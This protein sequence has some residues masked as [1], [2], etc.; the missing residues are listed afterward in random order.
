MDI[1]N[2]KVKPGIPERKQAVDS[3]KLHENIAACGTTITPVTAKDSSSVVSIVQRPVPDPEPILPSLTDDMFV[4]E[5]PSFIVPYVYE[6]PAEVHFRTFVNKLGTDLE[7]Q[8]AKEEE[9]RIQKEKEEKEKRDKE[10]QLRKEQGQDYSDLLDDNKK[11]KDAKEE[12]KQKKK[13]LKQGKLL[14]VQY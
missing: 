6:K 11:D 5:A 8:K 14:R 4:V 7:E 10:I 9:L 1:V 13:Q 2:K 12:E 3:K